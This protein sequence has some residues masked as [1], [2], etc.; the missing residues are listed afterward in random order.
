MKKHKASIIY[1]AFIITLFILLKFCF[2]PVIISGSSME[3][4]YRENQF[5]I[6][7]RIYGNIDRFDCVV[8]KTNQKIIFKR[9]IGFPGEQIE[10]KDNIL[11]INGEMIEDN[12]GVGI[13]EDFIVV[14]D[15][16]FCMGD[17]REVSRDSRKL[18]SFTEDQIIAKIG[19]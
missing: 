10:Y 8:I 6:A 16:Y 17:N 11:Y 13:T 12:Y 7:T 1:V 15:G 18:G 9:V 2:M 19:G 14:C 4:H 5:A 3:P